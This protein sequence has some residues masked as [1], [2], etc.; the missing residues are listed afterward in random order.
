MS[1]ESTRV[2]P[3]CGRR[4]GSE[5][6]EVDGALLIPE[7]ALATAADGMIGR[8]LRGRYR[9]VRILGAGGMGKVYAAAQ[10]GL[11]REVAVKVLRRLA[12]DD[13][14]EQRAVVLR[15]QREVLA[16]SRLQ[17]P[18]T[19][20]VYDYGT[21]EDGTLYLVME[22][23]RGRT[24]GEALRAGAPL[25]ADAVAR[26]GA[27]VCRSLAE[28]HELGVVHRDLKPDN[29]FLVD[30]H[31]G[32]EQ[33]KVLDF[34]IAKIA[35]PPEHALLGT[36]TT[37]RTIVGTAAYM[38]P[39]QA[40]GGEVTPATDLYSL[41]VILYQAIVGALPFEGKTSVSMMVK[42]SLDGAPELPETVGGRAV[43][44]ELGALVRR[45]LA[46]DPAARPGSALE[47]AEALEALTREAPT[48]FAGPPTARRVVRRTTLV[49]AGAALLVA[50]A[51]VLAGAWANAHLAEPR[52]AARSALAS[53]DSGPACPA[54]TCPA[55]TCPAP[56][57]PAPEPALAVAT[58]APLN[59]ESPAPAVAEPATSSAAP[60]KPVEAPPPA[61]PASTLHARKAVSTPPRPDPLP[62]CD[63]ARCPFTHA[64]RHASGLVLKGD[65]FCFP[66]F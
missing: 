27:Q 64:C 26:L 18:N 28:A 15:F 34:G 52:A 58:P 44:P 10:I 61:A 19:I 4:G 54:P 25:A 47:V 38:A 24:L 16:A 43:P 40:D 35:A 53:A 13:P 1:H 66:A 48:P 59:S 5:F 12:N 60:P 56:T 2:C 57:C 17:H 32:L 62:A 37:S 11:Q 23:L 14:V 20:R 55:P 22:L 49:G 31:G 63:S 9:L 46:R 36:L 41:G 6:C 21:A 65:E 51:L 39:E 30:V 7:E 3:A 42:R 8:V 45:L 50:G 33:V 29:V